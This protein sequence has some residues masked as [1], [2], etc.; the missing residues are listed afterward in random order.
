MSEK[1]IFEIITNAAIDKI[2][3]QGLVADIDKTFNGD[4]CEFQKRLN[5][6][7]GIKFTPV[8]VSYEINRRDS[9][10]T[11]EEKLEIKQSNELLQ[12]LSKLAFDGEEDG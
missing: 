4:Y 2:K 7:F 1:E 10:L 5:I 8:V 3:E 6:Y 12:L 9:E 11:V